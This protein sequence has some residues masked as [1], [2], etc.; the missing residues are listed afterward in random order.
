MRVAV[1]GSRRWG[2]RQAVLDAIAALPAGTVVVSGACE[3]P[4]AWAAEAA[5]ARGL[6]VI[7]FKPDLSGLPAHGG[8]RFEVTKRY[9]ARNQRVA[10]ACERVVAFVAADRKGGTEDTIRRARRAGKLVEVVEQGEA[11]AS[12]VRC[13]QEA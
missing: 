2:K 10:D 1:V 6:Q 12:A 5:R 3:G 11:D 8:R 9:H 4:D 13:G 7:E